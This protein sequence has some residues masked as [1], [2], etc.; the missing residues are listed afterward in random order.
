MFRLTQDHNLILEEIYRTKGKLAEDIILHPVPVYDL[1][2]QWKR[3]FVVLLVGASQCYS[4]IVHAMAAL[5][6][7]A[8]KVSTNSITAMLHPTQQISTS[9][10]LATVNQKHTQEGTERS[11]RGAPKKHNHTF[12]LEVN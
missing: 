12:H 4:R 5:V 2:Q 11:H 1:P 3:P 9:Y 10:K 6:I 8:F 7:Q